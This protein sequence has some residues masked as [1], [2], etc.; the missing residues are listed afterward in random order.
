MKKTCAT[1]SFTMHGRSADLV[2]GRLRGRAGGTRLT[3]P[4]YLQVG[5]GEKM[6]QVCARDG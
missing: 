5:L 4:S 2:S 6:V 3:T 1:A